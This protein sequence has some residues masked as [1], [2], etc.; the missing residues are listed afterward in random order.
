MKIE[1]FIENEGGSNQK[2]CFNE[3]TLEY[4][5]TVTISRPYPYPYGLIPGTISGDG[6]NLDCFVITSRSIKSRERVNVEPVGMME[7]FEDGENDHKILAIFP[8][9]EIN[10]TSEIQNSIADFVTHA[11]EHLRGK[12][13][14]VGKFYGKEEAEQL[15]EQSRR[16]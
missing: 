15:I 3:Q 11:F 14:K 2:H 10:I 4:I 5:K 8:E 16:G 6:D 7:Q 13:I 1:V 9:E 12:K